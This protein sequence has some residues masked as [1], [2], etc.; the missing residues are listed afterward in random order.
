MTTLQSTGNLAVE[1]A[2]AVRRITA[3]DL[4]WA[5][6]EG[7]R[8][9]ADKRGDLLFAGFIY[10][11]VGLAAAAFAMNSKLLPLLFPTVAG[12]SI[13]GPAV[14]SGFYEL[15]RRRELGLE[16]GW[17]HFFD[18]LKGRS[19]TPLL[20]LTAMLVAIFVAWIAIAWTIFQATIAT[21]FPMR[22]EDFLAATFGTP[23]GWTMILLGNAAGFVLAVVTL[24][25][26]VVSFPMVVDKPVDAHSAVATSLAAVR[27]N[28]GAITG[29]GLRVAG[30]LFLGCLP[31]FIGLAVVLP[32]V[33]YATWHLYTRIVER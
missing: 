4:N 18:P 11:L 31:F 23:Q 19:R 14:A 8:D 17:S 30:L 7:W 22:A 2:P 26:T 20:M 24:W 21:E 16:A 29:W 6:A 9:F 10:T 3:A 32:V 5:L 25:L 15:A 12:I 27:A 33:G 13:L 1:A 28:P